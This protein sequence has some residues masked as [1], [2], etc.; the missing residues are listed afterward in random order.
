ME[1][2]PPG[3]AFSYYIGTTNPQRLF[4][5]GCREGFRMKQSTS[6]RDT[7]V[8]L[9]FGRP[10]RRRHH[11]PRG[12]WH[13]GVSLFKK[14]GFAPVSSVLNASEAY[15]RGVWNCSQGLERGHV[16]IA[17]GTSNWGTDV[18]W[19]HGRNWAAMVNSA[20]AWVQD[21]RVSSRLASPEPTT[22]SSRG[23]LRP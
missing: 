7:I 2:T 22:S 15:A 6:L 12:P 14:R 8:V 3:T 4:R 18:T 17:I 20:N 10:V 21:H 11:H 9:D 19:W 16:R 23:T 5:L 13:Y 1:P